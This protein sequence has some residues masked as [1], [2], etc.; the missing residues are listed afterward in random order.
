M[1]GSEAQG[2]RGDPWL[3]S[4]PASGAAAWLPQGLRHLRVAGAT[5]PPHSPAGAPYQPLCPLSLTGVEATLRTL[6]L[7]TASHAGHAGSLRLTH[8]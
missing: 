4:L 8:E 7:T 1:A 6:L 2:E 5:R 3:L